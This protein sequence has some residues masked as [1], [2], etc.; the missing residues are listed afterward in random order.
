MIV[1]AASAGTL[2]TERLRLPNDVL[3]E[4]AGHT[5]GV[6]SYVPSLRVRKSHS[7]SVALI[8]SLSN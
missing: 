6:V 8:L 5:R 7:L 3:R 1:D 2:S 4:I